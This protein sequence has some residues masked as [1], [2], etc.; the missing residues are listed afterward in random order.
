[1]RKFER[2]VVEEIV[3]VDTPAVQK[4]VKRER[5]TELKFSVIWIGL[6]ALLAAASLIVRNLWP[7]DETRV[8]GIAW[9]MWSRRSF[10]VPY[11][12]GQPE[13]HPPFLFWL[14][15]AG[16]SVFGVA[17]WWARLVAPLGA[18]ASLVVIQR[19]ARLL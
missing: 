14:I 3:M 9:E 11:L 17:E 15:H 6:W 12:N 1:M 18:L 7:N 19:I 10:L 8:L 2:H 5:F 13:L 4:A 16:W